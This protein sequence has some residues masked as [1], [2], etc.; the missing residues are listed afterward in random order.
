MPEKV[1][2][3]A[4][5][6]FGWPRNLIAQEGLRHKAKKQ[7]LRAEFWFTVC[8]HFVGLA[9]LHSPQG[10]NLLRQGACHVANIVTTSIP[11]KESFSVVLFSNSVRSY[12]G[13]VVTLIIRSNAT[14]ESGALQLGVT[15][16]EYSPWI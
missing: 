2:H 13:K 12:E 10:N 7:T 5:L 16:K 9:W 14:R 6:C 11:H 1:L 15:H 4:S 3:L 8:V